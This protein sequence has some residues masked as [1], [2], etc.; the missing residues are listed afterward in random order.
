MSKA[1]VKEYMQ[2]SGESKAA[3]YKMIKEGSLLAT[4]EKNRWVIQIDDIV[5]ETV[6]PIP[7]AKEIKPRPARSTPKKQVKKRVTTAVKQGSR[8]RKKVVKQRTVKAGARPMVKKNTKSPSVSRPI[9]KGVVKKR[10]VK[11]VSKGV[12]TRPLRK[13]RARKLISKRILKRPVTKRRR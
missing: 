3:V 13:K 10:R 8:V 11:T 4:K 2:I 9:T 12:S 1:S 6:Q 7:K 5:E